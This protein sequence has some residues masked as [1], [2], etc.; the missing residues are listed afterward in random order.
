MSVALELIRDCEQSGVKVSVNGQKLK[1][2]APTN[3]PDSMK[4]ALRQYKAEIIRTLTQRSE[5][6]LRERLNAMIASGA[7][8]DVGV[9]GFQVVGAGHLSEAAKHYLV[10]N[11]EQI[12][13]VQQQA[14]LQK[15]LSPVLFPDFIFEVKERAAILSDGA[16]FEPKFETVRDVTREWFAYLLNEMPEAN[17]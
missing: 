9:F 15:H 4:D 2:D 3:L 14:L 12:L 16:N 5:P 10:A 11:K 13:C 8:F 17:L 7:S 6:T 1:I